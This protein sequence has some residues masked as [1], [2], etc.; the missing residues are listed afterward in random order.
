MRNEENAGNRSDKRRFSPT[1]GF[2]TAKVPFIEKAVAM[3]I[4][5][6]PGLGP[7]QTSEAVDWRT[8][9]TLI[10]SAPEII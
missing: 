3:G 6:L 5:Q 4:I 2:T 9:E 1:N 10:R 7:P 8:I